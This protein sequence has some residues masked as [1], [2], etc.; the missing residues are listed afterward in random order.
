VKVLLKSTF[1]HPDGFTGQAGDVIDLPDEIARNLLDAE[2]P[3]A[4]EVMDDVLIVPGTLT[5]AGS[6]GGTPAGL[7][8]SGQTPGVA[9]AAPDPL[10]P[11]EAHADGLVIGSGTLPAG[12]PPED[13]VNRAAIEAAAEAA[14]EGDAAADRDAG[15]TAEPEPEAAAADRDADT[16]PSKKVRKK[17]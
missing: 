5:Q 17:H 3:A 4:E 13:T 12:A 16:E 8:T 14:P 2:P 10:Q 1:A 9:A 15:S 11:P 6:F 7:N